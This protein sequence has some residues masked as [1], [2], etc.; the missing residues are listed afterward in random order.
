M[1]IAVVFMNYMVQGGKTHCE[2]LVHILRYLSN[3]IIV[4]V[5]KKNHR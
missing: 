1:W 4:T 3:K 5:L 2:I